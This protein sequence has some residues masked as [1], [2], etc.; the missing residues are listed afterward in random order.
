ME[1]EAQHDPCEEQRREA[2]LEQLD[3]LRQ[4]VQRYATAN[5]PERGAL[6]VDTYQGV[7]ARN[8]AV[9]ASTPENMGIA[10]PPETYRPLSLPDRKLRSVLRKE[11]DPAA[12]IEE[13]RQALRD[14]FPATA[15]KL[16][17]ELWPL[18]GERKTEYAYEL[19]DAA[20]AGLGREVLRQV[21]RTHR[22]HRDLPSVDIFDAERETGDG[23][24]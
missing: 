11:D 7:V 21:L 12:V 18:P 1:F 9:I 4:G 3:R 2:R 19:L 16:G 6:Y 5:R 10:A 15:L 8:T 14:G 22:E 13:A 20:Y 17:K 23:E 24:A